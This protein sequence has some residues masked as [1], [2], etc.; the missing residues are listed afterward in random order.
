MGYRFRPNVNRPTELLPAEPVA[1]EQRIMQELSNQVQNLTRL[2]DRANT[3]QA[4]SR[5]RC[6]REDRD[7]QQFRREVQREPFGRM[8][9]PGWN[10]RN[11]TAI[12]GLPISELKP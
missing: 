6:E 10:A 11:N 3:A 12:D 7:T 4:E 1:E 2:V 5:A 9:S 8:L